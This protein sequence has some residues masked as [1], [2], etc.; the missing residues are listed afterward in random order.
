ML[1]I[2]VHKLELGAKL[3]SQMFFP[4]APTR[5]VTLPT[6]ASSVSIRSAPHKLYRSTLRPASGVMSSMFSSTSSSIMGGGGVR[7]EASTR[8]LD[9]EGPSEPVPRYT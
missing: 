4:R 9:Q 3:F 8:S 5:S 6:G 7:G 1:K 2:K